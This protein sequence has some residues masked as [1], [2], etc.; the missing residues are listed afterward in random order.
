M[1]RIIKQVAEKLD[2]DASII[3]AVVDSFFKA[4]YKII[5]R[6]KYNE[7]ESFTNI[8]TN[9]VIPGL[10]RFIVTKGK[11]NYFN[12]NNKNGRD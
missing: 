9:L 10:G 7:L 5:T 6:I 2:I 1:Q 3:N 4:F 8:K 11:K 12:K